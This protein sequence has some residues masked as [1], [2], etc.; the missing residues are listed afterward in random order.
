V[1]VNRFA[2]QIRTIH[3]RLAELYQGVNASVGTEPEANL[4]VNAIY[5]DEGEPTLRWIVDELLEDRRDRKLVAPNHS[6]L[7]HNR[8]LHSYSKGEIIRNNYPIARSVTETRENYVRLQASP[9]P[10]RN[11]IRFNLSVDFGL[12]FSIKID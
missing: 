9:N 1:D 12:I 2:K 3:L 6:A 11:I 7:F 10:E 8:P 5:N 4:T